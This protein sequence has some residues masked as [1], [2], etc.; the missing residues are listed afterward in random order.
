MLSIWRIQN[1]WSV[2]RHL[3][4]EKFLCVYTQSVYIYKEQ[5]TI[6][7]FVS[8]Y[9]VHKTLYMFQAVPLSI[10]RSTKLYIQLLPAAIVEEMESCISLVL[11]CKC[12]YDARTYE[13]QKIQSFLVILRRNGEYFPSKS[14][15]ITKRSRVLREKLTVSPL[16]IKLPVFYVTIMFIT[17]FTKVCNLPLSWARQVQ[18][19]PPMPNL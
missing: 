8:I 2:V 6:C 13:Y 15:Q 16:V 12:N 19:I 11:L 7:N 3:A 5:P 10:I 14:H 17:A 18:T 4:L 1:I 9:L